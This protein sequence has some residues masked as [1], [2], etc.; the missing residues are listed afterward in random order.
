M[1][2]AN[3]KAALAA[4]KERKIPVGIYAIRCTATGET[5]VGQSPNL[6]AIQN[7]LLFALRLGSS[8]H[9]DL[10]KVWN[11]HGEARVTFEI[12]ERMTDEEPSFDRDTLLKERTAHWRQTLGA[13]P[14]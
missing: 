12:L 4:Y 1:K 2:S 6:E 13:K 9:K 7:R 5:W 3:K 8:E 10:Q 11:D 14:I